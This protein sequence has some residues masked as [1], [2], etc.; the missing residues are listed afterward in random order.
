MTTQADLQQQQQQQQQQQLWSYQLGQ[1]QQPSYAFG[2]APAAPTLPLPPL[3]RYPRRYFNGSNNG[4]SSNRGQRT[5]ME[6]ERRIQR[7]TEELRMPSGRRA[8]WLDR[9]VDADPDAYELIKRALRYVSE[10]KKNEWEFILNLCEFCEVNAA[11]DFKTLVKIGSASNL[12]YE[13]RKFAKNY[14]RRHTRKPQP[15]PNDDDEADRER[16][17]EPST[18]RQQ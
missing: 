11:A 4:G 16:D 17:R 9:L 3:P 5:N 13:V 8:Y 14:N 1:Y 10:E 18:P 2:V 12:L 6:Q 7:L 15:Q